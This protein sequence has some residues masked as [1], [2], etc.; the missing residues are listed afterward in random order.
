MRRINLHPEEKRPNFRILSIQSELG[1][2]QDGLFWLKRGRNNPAPE[3]EEWR[4]LGEERVG[5]ITNAETEI[6]KAEETTKFLKEL[7]LVG[8]LWYEEKI[9]V[10]EV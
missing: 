5:N 8:I 2:W 10:S 6:E 1:E 3:L 7:L 4:K 9:I